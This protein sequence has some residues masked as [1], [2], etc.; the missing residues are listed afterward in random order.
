MAL[1]GGVNLILTP[2]IT[3]SFSKARMLSPEGRCKTFDAGASGYVRGE[4]CGML[5]LKRLKDAEADGDRIL[6]VI[7][8]SA[9][10][11]D[12]KSN[13][14]TAPNGPAQEAVI[15]GIHRWGTHPHP[16]PLRAKLAGMGSLAF[17]IGVVACGRWV[18]FT[19]KPAISG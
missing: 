18:G 9:V 2:E 19:L 5:V 1:A 10:N 8:G 14:I 16:I 13:G 6:A 15:R 7:R 11:Q 12:G 4:G 3:V 17:W